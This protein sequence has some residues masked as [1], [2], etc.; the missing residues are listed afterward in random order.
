MQGVEVTDERAREDAE[1]TAGQTRPSTAPQP[2]AGVGIEAHVTQQMFGGPPPANNG[3][4]QQSPERQVQG[5]DAPDLP[6]LR[7]AHVALPVVAQALQKGLCVPQWA[8]DQPEHPSG[9]DAGDDPQG[10]NDRD[11]FAPKPCVVGRCE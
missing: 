8:N 11:D 3:Q 1:H 10:P 2:G 5:H 4:R 9:V 7:S 6:V